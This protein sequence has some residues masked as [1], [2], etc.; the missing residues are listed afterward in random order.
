MKTAASA[1]TLQV[2]TSDS[3]RFTPLSR[4]HCALQRS[5]GRQ[6]PE[7]CSKCPTPADS[8][9]NPLP[10]APPPRRS[11]A[12][13]AISSRAPIGWLP[14]VSRG[15]V[16]RGEGASSFRPQLCVLGRRPHCFAVSAPP[17]S[18]ED[19]G[20]SRRFGWPCS[21]Q[22][23]R[24]SRPFQPAALVGGVQVGEENGAGAPRRPGGAAA[25][26]WVPTC[27]P[28]PFLRPGLRPPAAGRPGRRLPRALHLPLLCAGLQ[29][30]ET[31]SA[32]LEGAVE[33]AAPRRRQ[34]VSG[35]AG[36]GWGF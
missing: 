16:G 24:R 29:S 3:Q 32:G 2:G 33:P 31:A 7:D 18:L 14:C 15:A 10:A 13:D 19:T 27:F 12:C 17:L 6:T 21:R 23:S 22:T 1:D 4:S 8:L 11:P 30:Q 9:R 28:A 5:Q 36:R 34:P 35:V 26:V 20:D 25:A